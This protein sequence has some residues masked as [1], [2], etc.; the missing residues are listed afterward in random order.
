MAR[1]AAQVTM[2]SVVDITETYLSP[3]TGELVTVT[4]KLHTVVSFRK[5][6]NG[7]KEL[8]QGNY[9]SLRGV[10]ESGTEYVVTEGALS[11][12]GVTDD[13]ADV[14]TAWSHLNVVSLG[15]ADNFRL[16]L[17]LHFT[18]LPDGTVAAT[19]IQTQASCQG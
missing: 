7:T 14:L 12:E 13:A 17:L 15:S 4:G 9:A 6:K 3:C 1:A 2:N 16:S 5:N 10:G 18:E 8:V 19:V 11:S